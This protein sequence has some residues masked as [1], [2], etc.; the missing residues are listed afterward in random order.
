[1]HVTCMAHM[2]LTT[3]RLW[4]QPVF[5]ICMGVEVHRG[6]LAIE[7]VCCVFHAS[8]LTQTVGIWVFVCMSCCCLGDGVSM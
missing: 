3:L 5:T 7:T 1:M 6:Y 8:H 2:H 4:P